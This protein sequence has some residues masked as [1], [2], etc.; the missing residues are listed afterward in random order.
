MAELTMDGFDK[1]VRMRWKM[2]SRA[3]PMETTG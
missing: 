2:G 1:Q 3:G